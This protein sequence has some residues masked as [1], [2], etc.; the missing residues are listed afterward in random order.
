VRVNEE[1][2]Q[3][4][5][6]IEGKDKGEWEGTRVYQRVGPARKARCK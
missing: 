4:K 5:A 3:D 2:L 1:A 6:E